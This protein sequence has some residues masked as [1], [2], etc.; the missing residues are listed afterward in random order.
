M[1]SPIK[2]A[3]ILVFNNNKVLLVK[4]GEKAGHLTG[5]YGIPG[6]RFSENEDEKTTAIRELKEET[7]I[8]VSLS[9]L[10]DYP[11]NLYTARIKKKDLTE[12]LFSIKV[13]VADKYIGN[14]RKTEETTPEWINISDLK[15]Y[16]LLPNVE[17]AIND[18][19]NYKSHQ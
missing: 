9:N 14:L 12:K 4:H 18:G 17:K 10:K 8:E 6:G 1:E 15:N 16:N 5:V 11:G 2:S 3:G 19:Y 7:G 13:F